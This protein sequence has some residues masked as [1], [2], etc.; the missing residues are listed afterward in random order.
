MA[1]QEGKERQRLLM[2][3]ADPTNSKTPTFSTFSSF[4]RLGA[5]T[6]VERQFCTT[7]GDGIS[8]IVG[9]MSD[10]LAKGD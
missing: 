4:H 7:D 5:G 9:T 2:N 6:G 8:D 10:G 3:K 1:I